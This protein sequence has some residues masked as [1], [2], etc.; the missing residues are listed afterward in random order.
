MD[1]KI[2]KLYIEASS[3]CNLSCRMCFRKSWID[4]GFGDLDPAVFTSLLDDPVLAQTETVFFGGMGEP[5]IHPHIIDMVREAAERGKYVE[6]ITNGTLLK[7]EMSE[8]LLS[9]GLK[10][11]W[12]S[13]DDVYENYAKI[14]R[15]GSFFKV[16][17][18]LEDFNKLRAGTD[19]RLGMTSVLMKDNI[20]SLPGIKE[21]AAQCGADDLN[22]SHMIPCRPE[23]EEQ[24]LWNMSFDSSQRT[25]VKRDPF[26]TDTFGRLRAWNAYYLERD[27]EEK[28]KKDRESDLDMGV[29]AGAGETSGTEETS[30]AENELN[31]RIPMFTFSGVY[32]KELFP[33]I[34]NLNEEEL[35]S[36]NGN[37][38]MRR[39]NY[40]RFIEEGHCFVRW[41]GDVA[42]CMGLLHSSLTYLHEKKRTV[43]RHTF[44]NVYQQS[45][46]EIWNSEE[47]T[48]F[49]EQVHDFTYSPCL[50]CG[51]CSFRDENR[52]DCTGHTDPVCGACLWGQGFISCP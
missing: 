41:D 5:L 2:H 39:R 32:Q 11:L 16:V 47:Y 37:T 9:A 46:S 35:F 44:G 33:D 25:E 17:S 24:T 20:A 36:W 50:F 27:R 15:G 30:E 31:A 48:D 42:P 12:I 21:F 3:R 52:A 4:E 18:Y 26:Y 49:R 10:R 23:D 13:V 1:N 43:W 38:A 6:L 34:D 19:V 45:L 7:P 29:N 40:C 14:Q 28:E 51:G 22:L 8:A